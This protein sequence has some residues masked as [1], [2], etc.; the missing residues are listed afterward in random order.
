MIQRLTMCLV[1]RLARKKRVISGFRKAHYDL[2]IV[3]ISSSIGFCNEPG[4][5]R[6]RIPCDLFAER[7]VAHVHSKSA[8]GTTCSIFR[9][10]ETFAQSA[11][12]KG[13]FLPSPQ[14]LTF[15]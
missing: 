9:W 4:L 14:K 10:A 15:E 13:G 2:H 5:S 7:R 8:F 1:S 6:I 3:R 12:P 11:M